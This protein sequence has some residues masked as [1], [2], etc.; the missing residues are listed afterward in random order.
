MFCVQGWGD[1]YYFCGKD[2]QYC[3]CEFRWNFAGYHKAF[4]LWNFVL[5]AA[6]ALQKLAIH[7]GLQGLSP[8]TVLTAMHA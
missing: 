5:T 1:V 4:V 2:F 8:G 3:T 6:L 7:V